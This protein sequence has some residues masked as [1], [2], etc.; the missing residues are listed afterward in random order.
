MGFTV[1]MLVFSLFF[2]IWLRQIELLFFIACMV[3]TGIPHGATDHLVYAHIQ[4][5]QGHKISYPRF[6]GLYLLGIIIYG[7]LWYF[8]PLLSLLG[9]LLI[10]TYHFGQSQ[11]LYL[12]LSE[13]NPIKVFLYLVWGATILS[14]IILFHWE[15]SHEILMTLLPASTLPGVPL[16]PWIANL[17]WVLGGLSLM[18]LMGAYQARW[19]NAKQL[20]CEGLN[21]LVL[22]SLFYVSTL[23]ISFAV[24]F[25]SWHALASIHSE[26][27]EMHLPQDSR[28]LSAF[29]KM[30]WPLSLI[31]I[32]GL[33][34]LLLSMQVI[35]AYISPYLIFFIAISTLTLPH[36]YFMD[37][38]YQSNR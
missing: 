19:M 24:Y 30:A 13:K 35:H 33:I 18:G 16:Q 6:L 27:K 20:V 37:R 8:L 4:K 31:S 28:T 22:L 14:G 10:S 2:P 15:A 21:L 34:G 17:P 38:L 7:A 1:A 32:V 36:M 23:L 29:F 25:A 3:F 12:N 5:S 9:F 26:L 11:L